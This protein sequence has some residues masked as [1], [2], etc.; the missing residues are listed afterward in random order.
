METRY[1]L[2][3]IKLLPSWINLS[4]WRNHRTP[5]RINLN[6]CYVNSKFQVLGYY[7]FTCLSK[8]GHIHEGKL[9]VSASESN[10][11]SEPVYFQ[12]DQGLCS[13]IF[14]RIR[15]VTSLQTILI[16]N[17]SYRNMLK[18]PNLLRT[19]NNVLI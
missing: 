7:A 1:F 19:M 9:V 2:M 15:E 14:H 12:P 5:L 8:L 11:V 17:F 4:L 6:A 16:F 13:P 10:S 3:P 18:L